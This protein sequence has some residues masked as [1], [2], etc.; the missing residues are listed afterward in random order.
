MKPSK[1]TLKTKY[2][3]FN[4]GLQNE[5]LTHFYE[6]QY[7]LKQFVHFFYKK[8][9]LSVLID[10]SLAQKHLEDPNYSP[11]HVVDKLDELFSVDLE[12]LDIQQKL[13]LKALKIFTLIGVDDVL[14]FIDI[15]GL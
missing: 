5:L 8:E 1:P 9:R 7:A 13:Y 12:I 11:M 15:K 10:R 3:S 14:D 2:K 4:E 6:Y